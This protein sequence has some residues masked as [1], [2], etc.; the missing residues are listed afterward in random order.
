M[1]TTS[2]LL[3]YIFLLILSSAGRCANSY[4]KIV[5]APVA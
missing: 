1:I 5:S 4:M 2:L 3:S